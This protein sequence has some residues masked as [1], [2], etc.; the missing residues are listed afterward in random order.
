MTEETLYLNMEN[1][2]VSHGN[3]PLLNLTREGLESL[4][5]DNSISSD[6]PTDTNNISIPS[7]EK[8]RLQVLDQLNKVA[9]FLQ[10][11][12]DA[13]QVGVLGGDEYWSPPKYCTACINNECTEVECHNKC[14]YLTA[15]KLRKI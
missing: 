7:I 11:D 1:C 6:H 14:A 2:V 3:Q 12:C 15:P 8:E 5:L 9:V 13:R 4:R 10:N